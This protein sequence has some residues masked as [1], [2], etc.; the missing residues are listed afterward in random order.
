MIDVLISGA[1]GAAV[2]QSAKETLL[3]KVGSQSPISCGAGAAR[4]IFNGA[5]DLRRVTVRHESE[6]SEKLLV[7]RNCSRALR[8]VLIATAPDEDVTTARKAI[9]AAEGLLKDIAV[10]EFVLNRLFAAALIHISPLKRKIK[11]FPFFS[12]ILQEINQKSG[13]I[14]H[15]SDAWD[16]LPDEVFRSVGRDEGRVIAADAGIFYHLASAERGA[17]S[18]LF[19]KATS[20]GLDLRV[21]SEILQ[22]LSAHQQTA[23][24]RRVPPRPV[25]RSGRDLTIIALFNHFADAKAAVEAGIRAGAPLDRIAMLANDSSGD[26]PALVINPAYAREQFDEDSTKQSRFVTLGEVGIGLG[27]LTGFLAYVSPVAIPGVET[28]VSLGGAW[29]PTV[30]MSVFGS[31]VGV[32]IGLATG[33]DLSGK[34]ASLYT[35]GLKSGGT[36]VTATVDEWLAGK[37]SEAFKNHGPARLEQRSADWSAEGWVSLDVDAVSSEENYHYGVIA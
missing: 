32:V 18:S 7:A 1:A 16:N 8:L 20:A 10:K 11:K 25:P 13:E 21:W 31:V 30:V 23:K 33:H 5:D 27:G 9:V 12:S 2:W 34:D 6:I 4:F 35:D 14:R 37:V 15:L 28:L 29:V 19:G 22:G 26:H 17:F 36:L 3:L 24:A